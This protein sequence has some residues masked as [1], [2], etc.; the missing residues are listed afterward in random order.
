MHARASQ[1]FYIAPS[2]TGAPRG[3]ATDMIRKRAIPAPNR[4]CVPFISGLS[5]RNG[6]STPET[7]S[8]SSPRKHGVASG[9]QGGV[10]RLST[11]AREAPHYK[12]SSFHYV[13]PE[14][15]LTND[16][17]SIGKR[18]QNRR[19]LRT[20]EVQRRPDGEVGILVLQEQGRAAI[21]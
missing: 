19:V 18:H 15:A 11:P 5:S 2:H 16:W 12:T 3:S 1:R 6:A 13:R 9:A 8:T 7:G 4:I 21:T 20:V 10:P 17:F 14:S